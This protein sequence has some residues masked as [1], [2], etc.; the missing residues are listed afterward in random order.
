MIGGVTRRTLPHLS[1]VPHHH[2]NRP[3]EYETFYVNQVL[4]NMNFCENNM[5]FTEEMKNSK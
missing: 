5:Q 4:I 3:L 2:V 1:G